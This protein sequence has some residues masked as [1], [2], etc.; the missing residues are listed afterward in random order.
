MNL[1][2]CPFT[3]KPGAPRPDLR[4]LL[5]RHAVRAGASEWGVR[6]DAADNIARSLMRETD[7]HADDLGTNVHENVEPDHWIEAVDG[8]DSILERH[9]RMAHRAWVREINGEFEYGAA[10]AAYRAWMCARRY[11]GL[12][13]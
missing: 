8:A 6:L 10:D 9:R 2:P 11:C 12:P 13:T 3:V 4:A 7:P 1:L 5:V